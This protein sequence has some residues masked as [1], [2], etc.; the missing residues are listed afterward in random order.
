[1]P[2]ISPLKSFGVLRAVAGT[3]VG[4]GGGAD[5]AIKLG[6]GVGVAL[7]FAWLP[8]E[9]CMAPAHDFSRRSSASALAHQRF[10]IFRFGKIRKNRELHSYKRRRGRY[11]ANLNWSRCRNSRDFYPLDLLV[12]CLPERRR[13]CASFESLRE[14]AARRTKE[15]MMPPFTRIGHQCCCSASLIHATLQAR[16]WRLLE[17]RTYEPS[18]RFLAIGG[19]APPPLRWAL[20]WAEA[21]R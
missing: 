6:P 9:G 10:G 5:S 20:S 17:E 7:A 4:L 12:S 19:I 8:E 14:L 3:G 2:V 21:D 18:S 15:Q 16:C 1:M 11:P 13:I